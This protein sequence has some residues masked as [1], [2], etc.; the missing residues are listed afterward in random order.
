MPIFASKTECDDQLRQRI[1][2]ISGQ[3]FQKCF[4]CGTCSGSCPMKEHINV[5][6]RRVMALLQLGQK[7]ALEEAN[8]PW[9]CAACHVCLVRCP[10]SIDIPRVMEAI[11]QVKLRENLDQVDPRRIEKEKIAELPQIA[12]VAGLRKFTS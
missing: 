12:M 3:E 8:T 1:K 2:E 6:P 5:F 4:Q 11:R 9:I 10:R 7:K